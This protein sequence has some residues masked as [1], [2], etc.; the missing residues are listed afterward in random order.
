MNSWTY[1]INE[2]SAGCYDIEAIRDS[3]HS[4]AR[5]GF[6][7]AIAEVIRDSFHMEISFGTIPGEAAFHVTSGLKAFWIPTYYEEALGSW[8]V[9]DFR[10]KSQIEYDGKEFCISMISDPSKATIRYWSGRLPDVLKK[11]SDYFHNLLYFN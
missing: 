10:T 7:N 8:L 1:A 5:K 9:R 3:H 6:E 11:D 4:I 2:V